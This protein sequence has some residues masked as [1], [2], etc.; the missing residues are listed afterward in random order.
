MAAPPDQPQPAPASSFTDEQKIEEVG[1]IVA[2]RS[3]LADLKF[4]PDEI[5]ALVKGFNA[6]MEGKVA[7]YDATKIGPELDDFM[8]KKQDA[9]LSDL[10]QQAAAFFTKLKENKN[11]VE[12]S[13][14]LCYE[15]VSPGQ[16]AYP[17]PT[18]TVDVNYTGK[19]VDGTTF[20]SSVDKPAEFPL[21]GV[22]PG[23]TEGIQ[24]I[25]KG[26][27]IKLYVPSSLGYGDQAQPGIP[28]GS[29][30]IFEIELLD[31]KPTPPQ[32][33]EGAPQAAPAEPAPAAPAA[34][35]PGA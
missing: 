23:W 14:G 24:K 9:Y 32:P 21:S 16:G 26:G 27:K 31:V 29:A 2:K 3:Q 25:N 1:W 8:Q 20:D 19:L 13:T 12:T 30:L 17:K 18:D 11:V 7:P 28:P 34:P 35:P 10:K 22:I 15:I 5:A 33:A 4:S 6:A